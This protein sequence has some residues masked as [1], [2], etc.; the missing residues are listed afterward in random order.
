MQLRALTLFLAGC[1]AAGCGGGGAGKIMAET[2]TPTKEDPN[3]VLVPYLAPDISEITGIEEEDPEDKD[4]AAAP[5][6]AP[7]PAAGA[8]Q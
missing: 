4:D 3:A 6:P 8:K 7:A 5:A 1:L 2:P